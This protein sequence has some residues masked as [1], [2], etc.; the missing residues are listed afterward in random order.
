MSAA[1]SREDKEKFGLSVVAVYST[2]R[3]GSLALVRA[4]VATSPPSPFW[5]GPGGR[6]QRK[7]KRR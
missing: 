5:D 4:A 1:S 2:A 6:L 3:V 7:R